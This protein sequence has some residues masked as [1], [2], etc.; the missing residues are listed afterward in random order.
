MARKT[1]TITLPPP[2]PGTRRELIVHRWGEPGARPKVYLHAALHADELP[3]VLTLDHLAVRLDALDAEGAIRGEIVLLPYAN[4][5]GFDQSMGDNLIGRYRFADGGGNFNRTWPDL[6]PAAA[7]RI[8]DKLGDDAAANV[9]LV[10]DALLA[11]AEELPE[12]T[13]REAHQKALISR[14]IDADMVFDVHCDWRATLHLFASRDH[15]DAM[16]ALGADM[17]VPVMLID[18]EI[19]DLPFDGANSFP[20]RELR[21]IL[22]VGTDV[23]PPSC[24]AV[25][26]EL[27]GQLDVT[28]ELAARDAD[29]MVRYM[30]RRGVIAGEPGPV[31]EPVGEPTPLDAIYSLDAPTA[32]VLVWHRELGDRVEAGESVAE[33]V[34]VGDGAVPAPRHPVITRQSGL[35]FSMHHEPLHRPGERIG[36]VA[37]RDPIKRRPGEKLLSNR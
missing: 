1:E 26:I 36:K 18:D 32:G 27:R 12:A 17:G 22:G 10:R 8:A 25:T 28:D 24:F 5:I 14:S 34:E 23:L 33:I 3:G 7:E 11:A 16:A 20:W 30:M 21:D 19:D 9:A 6:A 4:P 37:G 13:E 35:L 29:N 15:V 31:P 2:A